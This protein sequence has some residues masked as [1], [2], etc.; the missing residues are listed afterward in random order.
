MVGNIGCNSVL[1][2]VINYIV[3]DD[4][5][6]ILKPIFGNFEFRFVINKAMFGFEHG[7]FFKTLNSVGEGKNEHV[8]YRRVFRHSKPDF[9][10]IADFWRRV[11]Q[12]IICSIAVDT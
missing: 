7:H 4:I 5:E 9:Y 6:L 12:K 10:F 8:F 1:S 11:A 2:I 3:A